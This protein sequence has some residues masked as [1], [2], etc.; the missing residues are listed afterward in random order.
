MQN[1]PRYGLRLTRFA[2]RSCSSQKFKNGLFVIG[3]SVGKT[4]SVFCG[5]PSRGGEDGVC[6]A[7]EKTGGALGVVSK[8][9]AFCGVAVWRSEFSFVWGGVAA[10]CN[11]LWIKFNSPKGSIIKKI[12]KN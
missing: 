6:G 3:S 8:G 4:V 11:A 12:S 5:S 10:D 2:R 1:S 9:E 7:V